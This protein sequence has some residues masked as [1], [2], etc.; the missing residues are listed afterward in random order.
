MLATP[1]EIAR[2][3]LADHL[4][5]LPPAQLLARYAHHRDPE[6]FV[7]LVQQFG[8]L[9]FGT[10]RRVLGSAADADDAFQAVF[11][12]L[13]RQ[14]DSF[15][16]AQ[17]LPA[18]LHRVSLRVARKALARRSGEASKGLTS[19]GSPEPV[20]PTDPFADVAWRD[21]RRVLDEEIDALAE[22]YRGPVV[23]CWLDGLTQ[24][25]AAGKLGLSLNTLKR[26]LDAGRA[27]LRSRLVRR[28]LAPVL[29]TAVVATPTGLRAVVP[30]ALRLLAVEL[31]VGGAVPE[32]VGALTVFVAATDHTRRYLKVGL[33][34]ALV[35]GVA[36]AGGLAVALNRPPRTPPTVT[37]P[38]PEPDANARSVAIAPEPRPVLGP[39]QFQ[40]L[41][42]P[43]QGGRIDW[44]VFSRD[45]KTLVASGHSTFGDA[46]QSVAG[47]PATLR[48]ESGMLETQPNRFGQAL[49]L[50]DV[51][52]G[53]RAEHLPYE[54]PEHFVDI[55]ISGQDR[56]PTL[57]PDGNWLLTSL[58]HGS[59]GLWDLKTGRRRGFGRIRH[60]AGFAAMS[61]DGNI[62]ATLMGDSGDYLRLWDVASFWDSVA[63]G[64][65]LPGFEKERAVLP[66]A[67]P[68]Y[69]LAF[70]PDGTTLAVSAGA[71]VRLWDVKAGREKPHDSEHCE[72]VRSIAFSPDGRFLAGHGMY[73][74][75]EVWV[76]DLVA[77]TSRTL[78]RREREES[79][80]WRGPLNSMAFHPDG[81]SLAVA[82][83][84]TVVIWD[85]ATGHKQATLAGHTD[86]IYA[87][88]FSPDGQTLAAACVGKDETY[89]MRLWKVTRKE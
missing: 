63:R 22:K 49:Q 17:A 5:A 25:E 77:G 40:P 32:R 54:R 58:S 84:R 31:G 36:T 73:N 2:R 82:D 9:V 69:A 50:W 15:R 28:G 7:G 8:P 55:A 52:G 14:A 26:R 30:E 72:Y 76:W 71:R 4:A 6:A 13:A 70:S 45:G 57:S 75:S 64:Q 1:A 60:G 67:W 23:L 20:D 38:N 61:P 87:L 56:N 48:G 37:P 41:G 43:L 39:L 29:V 65:P 81:R 33:A 42:K 88:T 89:R 35:A 83:G 19:P 68:V 3:A 78:S 18:W 16:D 34:L 27:L 74:V 11:L 51:G 80:V 86:E 21:V 47:G 10:C 12:A 66:C 46:L 53:K 85:A 44:L 24:D 59:F 79:G 62:L